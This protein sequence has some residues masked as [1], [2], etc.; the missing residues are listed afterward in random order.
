MYK[1]R[2]QGVAL[3]LLMALDK[4]VFKA[5][6][7]ETDEDLTSMLLMKV[8]AQKQSCLPHVSH[9]VIG[10]VEATA[11]ALSQH[12]E[13]CNKPFHGKTI[14]ELKKG[15]FQTN[16]EGKGITCILDTNE[17]KTLVNFDYADA[18]AIKEPMDVTTMVE[19]TA[20]GRTSHVDSLMQ[21]FLDAGVMVP[22]VEVEWKG[23]LFGEKKPDQTPRK[24]KADAIEATSQQSPFLSRSAGALSTALR[25]KLKKGNSDP[26]TPTPKKPANSPSS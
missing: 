18:V 22:S 5:D 3:Q 8:Q 10:S 16:E 23:E 7:T 13:Q 20:G 25:K 24:R 17:I 12:Y 6:C 9:H 15:Y 21:E 19:V 2:Q 1:L 4:E 14:E 11:A 26:S